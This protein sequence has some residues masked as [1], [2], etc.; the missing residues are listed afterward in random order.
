M[1][2]VVNLRK[3]RRA[4]EKAEAAAQA[5]ANRTGFGRTAAAKRRDAAEQ[6]KREALLAASRLDQPPQKPLEDGGG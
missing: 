4:R 5:A 6:A 2:E 1:G 3:W